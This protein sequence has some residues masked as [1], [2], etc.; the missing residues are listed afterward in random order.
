[1]RRCH[2]SSATLQFEPGQVR[3]QA[4]VW[5]ATEGQVPV[6]FALHVVVIRVVTELA[7][8]GV[9]RTQHDHHGVA[10]LHRHAVQLGRLRH[11][12]EHLHDRG[13]EPQQL[14][15]R[16]RHQPRVV[17]QGLALLGVAPPGGP[18]SSRASR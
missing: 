13:V 17:D 1:M 8:V 5:A 16:R 6:A 12:A 4:P 11:R 7:G 9:G 10:E 15:H 18:A 2:S 14:L 3:A